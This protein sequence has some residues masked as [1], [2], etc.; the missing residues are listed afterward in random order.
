MRKPW[1]RTDRIER[2]PTRDESRDLEQPGDPVVACRTALESDVD[3]LARLLAELMWHYHVTPPAPA[4][5]RAT[6]LNA[7]DCRTQVFLLAETPDGEAIGACGMLLVWD[8]WTGGR[9]CEL[10][11]LIVTAG[12]RGRGTGR[13]LVEA[14][15]AAARAGGCSRIYLLT[16]TW[17]QAG[18]SLYRRLGFREKSALYF[19][20]AL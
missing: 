1:R 15:A 3:L 14:A 17:N 18:P 9:A 10:R 2:M 5:L 12:H 19:E 20:R 4:E 13:S 16:E 11:D 7:L 8:P 6:L